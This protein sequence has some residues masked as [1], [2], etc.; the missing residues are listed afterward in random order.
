MKNRRDWLN[1]DKGTGAFV[2]LHHDAP[3]HNKSYRDWYA[4]MELKI[5]DCSRVIT[6]EFGC[7]T[8]NKKAIRERIRKAQVLTAYLNEITDTL[9][10]Y[11]DNVEV[12]KVE[13]KEYLAERTKKREADGYL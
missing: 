8:T 12:A 9:E 4:D 2:A 5:A 10:N 6:L 13:R 3:S 1:T 11:L 7:D